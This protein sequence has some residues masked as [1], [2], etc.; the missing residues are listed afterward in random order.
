M[1]PAAGDGGGNLGVPSAGASPKPS[2]KLSAVRS[3]AGREKSGRRQ[4]SVYAR[5]NFLCLHPGAEEGTKRKGITMRKTLPMTGVLVLVSLLQIGVAGSAQ[6][7]GKSFVGGWFC[8]NSLNAANARAPGIW[9][10]GVAGQL[11][12]QFMRWSNAKHKKI[13]CR[14]WVDRRGSP[15]NPCFAGYPNGRWQCRA[16]AQP[17]NPTN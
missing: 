12:S 11:G 16:I 4:I 14:R 13:Q 3:P 15:K 7:A 9:S 1:N 8:D 6:A 10:R 17:T 5:C 2:G